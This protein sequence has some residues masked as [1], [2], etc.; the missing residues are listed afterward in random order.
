MLVTNTIKDNARTLDYRS[1]QFEYMSLKF[2][3]KLPKKFKL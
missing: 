3:H 2:R 1:G